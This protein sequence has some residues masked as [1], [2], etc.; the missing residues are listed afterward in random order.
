MNLKAKTFFIVIGFLFCFYIAKTQKT[1]ID[2]LYTI[3]QQEVKDTNQVNNLNKL[4]RSLFLISDYTNGLNIGNKALSLAEELGFQKGVANSKNNIG[5]IYYF[6]GNYSEALKNHLSALRIREKIN[7]RKGIAASYN[8]LGN[9][10]KSQ[11][12]YGKALKFQFASLK[13]EKELG[14]QNGVA[15]SYNNIGIAFQN[16]KKYDKALE[17]HLMALT[18]RQKINDKYGL[19]YSYN[20]IGNVFSS[21]KNLDKALQYY[22]LSLDIEKEIK[23]TNGVALSY[24]NIGSLYFKQKKITEAKRY[25]TMALEIGKQIDAQD[26][27]LNA[28]E[29]LAQSDSALGNYKNAYENYKLF[30]RTNDIINNEE[31]A[32]K[33]AQLTV[34]YEIGKKDN[35]IALLNKEKEKQQIITD[36]KSKKQKIVIWSVI[37]GLVIVLVFSVFL[38]KRWVLA[39]EQTQIIKEQKMLVDAKQKEIIDSIKYAKR[40]Q[41]ALLPNEK[42]IEK[43][44]SRLNKK[45]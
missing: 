42:Y 14:N 4:C 32:K 12:D 43:N 45:L 37:L 29:V 21:Q 9:I 30:K 19:A 38:Y 25:Q 23:H 8:N 39:K 6:Q 15:A 10:Y 40:I 2:S 3:V 28:Y 27:M 16:Q 13:I 41:T 17:Y 5:N 20:N 33:S 22:F 31:N 36:A 1:E 44:I 34:Q 35:E 18:I 7:D 11:G 24:I 26:V